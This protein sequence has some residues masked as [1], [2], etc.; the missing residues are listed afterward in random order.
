MR[1][2]SNK[3]HIGFDDIL[4]IPQHSEVES[5]KDINLSVALGKGTRSINLKIPIIAA[6]MDT[7]CETDMAVAIRKEGGLGIIHRYMPVQEQSEKIKL[8]KALGGIAGGSVGARGEY[9]HDAVSL[10]GAGA[11]L[12]LI[13]V[14]NGHSSYAIEAVKALRQAFG[15]DVHIMAGNVASWDGFARLADAGAYSIRVG[16]GGGSACTTRVVSAHGVPTLSSILDIRD[17]VSYGDGPTLIADGGIRNSGDAA[18]ALAAGAQAL[19]LG[20]LLAGT[21][22][23]PGEVVDGHKVFRGMASREA[24]EAGR[25]TVSGVE[26]ISTTIPY[27]GSVNNIISDFRAGLS[28]ALSYTGVDNLID[29][30]HESMYNRVTSTTL[31]ETKPHAKKE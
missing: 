17:R 18:K 26:G 2:Y 19:M 22:E 6:P 11:S 23:S 3:E 4:L 28:S 24:Q 9:I 10:V 12:I 16:I 20:R 13:D 27:V 7:V 21:T 8:V 31:N 15:K 1:E 25:G 14:A 30:Y 29:F 5:R